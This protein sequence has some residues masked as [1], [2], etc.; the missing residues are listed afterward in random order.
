LVVQADFV[1]DNLFNNMLKD[2]NTIRV[3]IGPGFQ[4]GKNVMR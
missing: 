4:F 2:R 1:H 3:S